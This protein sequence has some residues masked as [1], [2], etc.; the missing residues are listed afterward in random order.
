M[1]TN[2]NDYQPEPLQA[3]R[4]AL[5]AVDPATLTAED[6]AALLSLFDRAMAFRAGAR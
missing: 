1:T 6:R 3:L 2:S 4:A 5:A